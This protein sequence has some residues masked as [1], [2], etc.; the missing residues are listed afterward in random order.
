MGDSRL[1][2]SSILLFTPLDSQPHPAGSNSI[3]AV[4]TNAQRRPFRAIE[5]A[6][7]HCCLFACG[8]PT[9]AALVLAALVFR[10]LM[11]ARRPPGHGFAPP[12]PREA[13]S[14]A[15]SSEDAPQRRLVVQWRSGRP[16]QIRILGLRVSRHDC[17][18]SAREDRVQQPDRAG[19][20]TLRTAR[21]L[22]REGS[23]LSVVGNVGKAQKDG[24]LIDSADYVVR[25]SD[26]DQ[27]PRAN[28]V[29]LHVM[30]GHVK[31]E[32]RA[33]ARLRHRVQPGY[34]GNLSL[35]PRCGI[36]ACEPTRA[37]W[38]T[39]ADATSDEEAASIR[40]AGSSRRPSSSGRMAAVR[41]RRQRALLR[42][43][44]GASQRASRTT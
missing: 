26:F 44:V 17:S 42:Q 32:A 23:S 16:G 31:G 27:R 18:G 41:L 21:S 5:E 34:R 38:E 28:R 2:A 14:T 30:N 12:L 11:A 13:L 40:V 22:V 20:E 6:L 8:C 43:R 19:V 39:P 10:P 1:P 35:L 29:D 33:A 15:V 36:E 9:F 3:L 25:F 24:A 7:S 37:S 4:A